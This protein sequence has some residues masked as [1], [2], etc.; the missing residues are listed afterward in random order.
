MVSNE[1]GW[2]PE[3]KGG[4]CWPAIEQGTRHFSVPVNLAL[5]TFCKHG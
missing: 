2:A 1:L 3:I 5:I 4:H